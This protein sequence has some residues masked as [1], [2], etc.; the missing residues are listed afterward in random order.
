MND[1]RALMKNPSAAPQVRLHRQV[2]AVSCAVWALALALE[3]LPDGRIAARGVPQFPLPQTCVSRT[4]L[5]LKCPGC[6]LT[7]SI[8]HVAAGELR[9]SWHDHR[10]GGLVGFLIALQVPYRILAL[11]RREQPLIAPRW[12][13]A[14]SYALIALLL[15]NWLVDVVAGRV[16]TP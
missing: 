4:W 9:A 12:Q 7:R 5:G 16:I 14:I 2:L 15:L 11:S 6:G 1:V 10:L 3:E 13:A 8:I